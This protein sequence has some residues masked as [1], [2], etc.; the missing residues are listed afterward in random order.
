MK[1]EKWNDVHGNTTSDERMVAFL[2]S[3]TDSYA[4]LQLK[5][6]DET[7]Q[8]R[9]MPYWHMVSVYPLWKADDHT[10]QPRRGKDLLC[11]A[12]CGGL[13]QPKALRRY[14]NP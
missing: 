1:I 11:H 5:R 3:S 9:F 10:G 8:F 2:E 4:V 13:H 6:I 14:G 7:E 12:S